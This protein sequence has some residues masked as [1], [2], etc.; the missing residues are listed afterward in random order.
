MG[1]FRLFFYACRILICKPCRM[2]LTQFKLKYVHLSIVMTRG[3]LFKDL[4]DIK[5]LNIIITD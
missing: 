1:F 2:K 5:Q 4:N 3:C